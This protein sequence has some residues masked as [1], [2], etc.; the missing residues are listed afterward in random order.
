MGLRTTVYDCQVALYKGMVTRAFVR[1]FVVVI[2][3]A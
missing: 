3:Y 2:T 1:V